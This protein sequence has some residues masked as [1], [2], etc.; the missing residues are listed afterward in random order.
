MSRGAA[1]GRTDSGGRETC[2]GAGFTV[3]LTK[4]K[5]LFMKQGISGTTIK[6]YLHYSRRDVFRIL[7]DVALARLGRVEHLV[8]SGRLA[9]RSR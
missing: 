4:R 7:A 6:H 9:S 8:V 3:A 2:T 1:T 5:R